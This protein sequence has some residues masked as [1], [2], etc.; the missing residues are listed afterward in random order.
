MMT[1]NMYEANLIGRFDSKINIGN[2]FNEIL[3]T[4]NAT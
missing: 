2:R 4:I 3:F 1:K